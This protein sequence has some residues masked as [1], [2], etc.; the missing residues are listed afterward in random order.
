VFLKRT[1]WRLKYTKAQL[2]IANT[3][4]EML[5]NPLLLINITMGKNSVQITPD[6]KREFHGSILSS[7]FGVK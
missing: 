5:L 1:Y 7:L 4:S 3:N 2:I 6:C